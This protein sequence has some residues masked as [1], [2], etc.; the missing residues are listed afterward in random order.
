MFGRSE[1]RPTYYIYKLYK[2]FGPNQVFAGCDHQN[3]GIYAAAD[4]AGKLSVIIINL[5]DAPL[6]RLLTIVDESLTVL[7]AERFDQEN[8]LYEVAADQ[9][10]DLN[11]I[12]I[13]AY[14]I[15]LLK[16]E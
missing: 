9:F 7:S 8:L 5:S 10:E 1:P 13:P 14:S 15:T 12:E 6:I 11:K 2:E 3:L 16:F 4:E